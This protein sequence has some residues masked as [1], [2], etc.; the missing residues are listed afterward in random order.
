MDMKLLQNRAFAWLLAALM[1]FA[2]ILGLGGMKLRSARQEVV[3]AF[4]TGNDG[5]S[6]YDD[7]LNRREHAYNLLHIAEGTGLKDSAVYSAAKK[8]WD[9]LDAAETPEAYYEANQA[10]QSSIDELYS[11]LLSLDGLENKMR[12]AADKQYSDFI[13]RLSNLRYDDFYNDLA[14]EY[15]QIC[16]AFPAKLIA[17]LTGNGPLPTF[18][19]ENV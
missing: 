5:F 14:S 19:E 4:F 18:R 8:A 13:G 1:I 7:L 16:M 12:V 10:L 11:G 6:P 2:A 9:L 15:N 3:A 17:S